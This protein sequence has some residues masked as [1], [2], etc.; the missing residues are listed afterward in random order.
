MRFRTRGQDYNHHHKQPEI[1]PHWKLFPNNSQGY[2]EVGLN[3]L[4][5]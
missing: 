4:T 3:L 2:L 1:F 5:A